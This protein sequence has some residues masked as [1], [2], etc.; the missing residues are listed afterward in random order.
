MDKLAN[1][2]HSSYAEFP[3]WFT[4]EI[5]YVGL[6]RLQSPCSCVHSLLNVT[7]LYHG[8]CLSFLI[9]KMLIL[10]F[11]LQCFECIPEGEGEE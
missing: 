2:E 3:D 11:F 10:L 6:W 7:G 5:T 9:Y 1:L 4:T 8:L